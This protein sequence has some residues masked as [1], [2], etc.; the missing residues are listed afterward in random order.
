[1]RETSIFV[2]HLSTCPP[3]FNIHCNKYSE[4]IMK[5]TFINRLL[6]SA[7]KAHEQNRCGASLGNSAAALF[8]HLTILNGSIMP[9][10]TAKSEQAINTQYSPAAVKSLTLQGCIE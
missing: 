4:I 8:L 2:V 7:L 6:I 5:K 10:Q 3:C 1:M 9:I